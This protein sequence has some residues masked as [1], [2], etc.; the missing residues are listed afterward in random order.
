M[1]SGQDRTEK[2]R[3]EDLQPQ[4]ESSDVKGGRPSGSGYGGG[5]SRPSASWE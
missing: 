1:T 4:D 3:P 2:E 5:P